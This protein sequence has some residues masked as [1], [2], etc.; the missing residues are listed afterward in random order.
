MK[1]HN[2][3]DQIVIATKYISNYKWHTLGKGKAVNHV[4]NS[5]QSLH[6][7]VRDLLYKLQTDFINILYVH[8]W[9]QVTS[10]KEVMDSL[11]ILVEQGKVLYLGISDSLAWVVLAANYYAEAH[12]KTPF[13]VYQGKWNVM[14]CDFKH[15]I[16]PMA[17]HFGM[18]LCPWDV[19]GGGKFQSKKA[20]KE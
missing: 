16:I 20:I 10:I 15:N 19:L 17:C 2:N 11:H 3:R 13:S 5:R 9:D 1:A 4:G 12:G 6:M 7:S 14:Y 18:V 8:W